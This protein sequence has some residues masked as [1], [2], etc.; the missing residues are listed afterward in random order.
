[1]DI[2]ESLHR[3]L[4]QKQSLADLFYARLLGRYP[5]V[6]GHFHGV[7]LR[8][9]GVLLTTALLVI[10]RY[11]THS[12]PAIEMYLKYLGT[13][14]QDRGIPAEMYPRFCGALLEALEHFHGP[15]WGPELAQQWQVAMDRTT[16]AML[17][18]YQTH[19]TV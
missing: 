6:R 18:G 5:E 11:Y 3:I 9:Q 7:N 13:R 16:R 15:A 14:H 12:Y 2:Q 10:E 17:E 19:F 4:E 1:M 8:H